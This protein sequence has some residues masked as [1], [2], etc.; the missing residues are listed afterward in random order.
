[1]V[2]ASRV[3]CGF[4]P[5]RDCIYVRQ[6][7]GKHVPAATSTHLTV[8]EFLDVMFSVRSVPCQTKVGGRLGES[9]GSQ[10]R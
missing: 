3:V 8:E 10:N 7:L 1:M 6:R 4:G 5:R 2:L 9:E